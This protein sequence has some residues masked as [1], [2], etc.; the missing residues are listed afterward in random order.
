[1]M[2]ISNWLSVRLS[3]EVKFE[4]VM[5]MQQALMINVGSSS[6]KWQLFEVTTQQAIATGLAERLNTPQAI[7]KIKFQDQIEQ[8][9]QERL[10]LQQVA[11][12]LVEKLP[13]LGL[14]QQ[15]SDLVAIGHRVVAGGERFKQPVRI[16]PTVLTEL[17]QLNDLAPLHNP[18]ALH[19]IKKM[20][21]IV[22]KVPQYAVFDSQFFTALPEMNAIYSLP[23]E[24]TQQLQIRRYGEH[25]ISH[26]Y[27]AQQAAQQL[28]QPLTQLKLVTLH[29]GSGASVAAIKAG[30]A[31]DTSMG[32]TPLT[33]LTMGTRAGDIDPAIVP[34]LMRKLAL[35]T[36]EAV[37]TLL[38]TQSGL[39]G[40]SGIATD[41]RDL[42]AQ[43]ATQSRAQLAIDIFVN[44]VVKYIGSY[45]AEM[46]GLDAIVFAGGIGENDP[47]LRAKICQQLSALG[48]VLDQK[49]NRYNHTGLISATNSSIKVLRIPTNEEL[50][51]L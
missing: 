42:T 1:M 13:A 29:L 36:P 27:L 50:A 37:L 44:R 35:T 14:I 48:V 9:Q 23:Y 12:L 47:N 7:F 49:H 4:E 43:A 39:L 51:M 8:I 38:N 34:Y 19:Y 2:S 11:N 26:G 33:G 45:F 20:Q 41:M 40:I 25:G 3:E 10:T 22:P 24:L 28:Q 15:W 5:K 30:Q 21:Q 31:F 32:L 18:P 6:L 17:T 46:Q 16:T